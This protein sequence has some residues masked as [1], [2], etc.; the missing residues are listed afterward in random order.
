MPLIR[1]ILIG[2]IGYLI[3]RSFINFGKAGNS[4]A[5]I[6]QPEKKDNVHSKKVSRKT[7]EYIDYEEIK[8]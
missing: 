6:H 1:Y 8:K 3:I 5:K 7:G 4:S 2:I